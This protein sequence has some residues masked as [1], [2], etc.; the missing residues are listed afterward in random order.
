[1]QQM[2]DKKASSSINSVSPVSPWS[3][4]R[5]VLVMPLN[6]TSAPNNLVYP[7]HLTSLLTLL[8]IHTWRCL[9]QKYTQKSIFENSEDLKSQNLKDAYKYSEGFAF[10]YFSCTQVPIDLI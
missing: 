5:N 2:Q 6:V 9:G 1:M 7:I 10:I 4:K 8:C 3:T